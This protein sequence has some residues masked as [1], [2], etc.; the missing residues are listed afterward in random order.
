MKTLVEI[1]ALREN[2]LIEEAY[3]ECLALWQ[4]MPEDRDVRTEFAKCIKGQA[5][6]AAK[7]RQTKGFI[8][9][10]RQLAALRLE[11]IGEVSMAN[12]F[13]WEVRVLMEGIAN[14]QP[15]YVATANEIWKIL[16][17]LHF[18]KPH[19][20]YTML[21]DT[22]L[23][24]KGG[25]NSLWKGF[26]D[27]MDWFGFDNFMPGD[28]ERIPLKNGKT[29]PSVVERV[30]NTYYKVL[31]GQLEEGTADVEKVKAFIGRLTAV[32]EQHPEFQYT[33]YH[34]TRLLIA[35]GD[36]KGAL[37]AVRP[38]V[39]RKQREYWVWEVLSETTDEAETKLSCC[40]KA[41]T[42]HADEK[43]LG[44]VHLRTAELMHELGHD[45]NARAE[46]RAMYE[47][48]KANE[49]N[50]PRKAIDMKQ[51]EWYQ[52]AEAPT[53]N[54][55]FYLNHLERAEDLLFLDNPEIPILITHYN[56]DK[57]VCNFVTDKKQRG[58]FF[59][60]GLKMQWKT[61]CLYTIRM[62]H[63]QIIDNEPTKVITCKPIRDVCPYIGIFF[64]KVEGDLV[65]PANKNFGFVNQE[66]YV[67]SNLLKSG[68]TNGDEVMG[69]AVIDFNKKKDNWGWRA[70]ALKRK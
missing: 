68:L 46:I 7:T 51:Q 29:M 41:L 62:A 42:C 17:Q 14:N 56:K 24:V 9:T 67:D 20:Y 55:L 66:V 37:E 18:V 36:K 23:K 13:S 31:T 8:E 19:K 57:Q 35:L 11:E 4:T 28:Y 3:Q 50:M 63:Q 49:W 40:C 64:K 45:G 15:L 38:F 47:V 5:A 70:I 54:H 53:S 34:K 6:A 69:T 22:M 2:G 48:Y 39:K 27:F 26:T 44:K 60:K 32:N 16:P 52:R 30:Y 65:I 43:F 61:N 12:Y 21:A 33:L 1:K 10:L 25:L 58:F 59:T